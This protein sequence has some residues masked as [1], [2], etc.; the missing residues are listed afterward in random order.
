MDQIDLS[1]VKQLLVNCRKTYREIA[2]SLDLSTNAIYSRV[3]N[4]INKHMIIA[5]TAKPS[6]LY[7][8]GLNVLI[9]GDS[10]NTDILNIS[11]KLGQDE[12]IYFVGNASGNYLYIDG[13]L[14]DISELHQYTSTTSNVA[15][16]SEPLVAIRTVPYRI[17][18]KPLKSL[19]FKILKSLRDNARKPI[20][21]IAEEVGISA[22][23]AAKYI[24]RMMEYHLVEFS[25]NFAPRTEGIIVSSFHIYLPPKDDF[26]IQYQKINQKYSDNI[27]YLQIFSNIPNLIIITALTSSNEET[28]NLY[29][30]LQ[31]EH[32]K[33]VEHHI[34]YYGHFFETWRDILYK[35]MIE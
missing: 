23:T 9:C 17:I 15:Q 5:F 25:I 24:D 11:K 21:E 26:S 27:L 10:S 2:E 20:S 32:F 22:K 35:K 14:R 13:Y 31:E 18:E 28:A 4:M 34:M 30:R 7:L 16:I 33:K 8:K 1:I 29:S 19:D 6:L 12:H 3:Q